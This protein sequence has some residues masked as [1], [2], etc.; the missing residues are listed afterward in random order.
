MG[1]LPY[2]GIVVARMYVSLVK[3]PL[4]TMLGQILILEHMLLGA[5]GLLPYLRHLMSAPVPQSHGAGCA[6]LESGSA[7]VGWLDA[8]VHPGLG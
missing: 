2:G 3:L 7:R 6:Y 4:Q 5:H 8:R 1:Y